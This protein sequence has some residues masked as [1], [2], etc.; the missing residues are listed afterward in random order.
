MTIRNYWIFL[1]AT[2]V[3]TLI[4]NIVRAEPELLSQKQLKALFGGDLSFAVQGSR[5]KLRFKFRPDGRWFVKTRGDREASGIWH[6][7]GRKIY[8]DQTEMRG[9]WSGLKKPAVCFGI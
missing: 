2:V 9:N 8:R 1:A 4:A 3:F 7:D 5:T 6:I